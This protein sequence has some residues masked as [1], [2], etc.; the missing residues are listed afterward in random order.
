[1]DASERIDALEGDVAGIRTQIDTLQS[2]IENFILSMRTP[3]PPPSVTPV[4]DLPPPVRPTDGGQIKPSPPAD[5]NGARTQGRAFLNSCELYINLSPNQFANDDAKIYWA[6]TYMK[7]E[8]AYIYVDRILRQTKETGSLP[9]ASWGDFRVEFIRHFCPL[10]ERQ[11]AVTRLESSAYHQARRSVD[12]YIDEFRDLVDVAGYGSGLPVV[13]KFRRG[14]NREIQD[15]IAQMLGGRPADDDIDA[16][17]KAASLCDENRLTNAAFNSAFHAPTTQHPP[18][19]INRAFPRPNTVPVRPAP[20]PA[21]NVPVPMDVDAA[22]SRARRLDLCYRCGQP[23]HMAR[24]CPNR[25]DI[26][27]LTPEGRDKLLQDLLA[28]VDV[29][30]ATEKGNEEVKL[31]EVEEQDFSVRNE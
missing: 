5:F 31:E 23:G 7:S 15:Q 30:E 1:M 29:E 2:T 21:A 10:N 24:T 13:V 11:R 14:L 8:R 27:I 4:I 6:F 17:Y 18:F 22:R 9:F 25:Q 3:N 26:R 28:L 16:W 19:P 12:D 20:T